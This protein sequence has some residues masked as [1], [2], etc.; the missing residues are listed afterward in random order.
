MT[1]GNFVDYIKLYACSEMGV[2]A[3]YIFIE[4]TLQK[5]VQRRRWWSRSCDFRGNENLWTLH[6]LKFK[7]ILEQAMGSTVAKAE[8]LAQTEQMYL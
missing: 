2:K 8:V 1:E 4:N 6:H 3:Q 5:E 7:N